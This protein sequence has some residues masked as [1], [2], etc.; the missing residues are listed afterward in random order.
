MRPAAIIPESK[1]LDTLLK[2]FRTNRSHMAIVV[3]EYGSVGGLVTIEDV[4]EQI[5]GEIEDEFDLEGDEDGIQKV[6]E[7]EYVLKGLTEIEEFNEYFSS[8][9]DDDEYETIGGILL[10]AF[11]YVPSKDEGI[12]IE[13]FKFEIVAADTRKIKLVRVA[14]IDVANQQKKVS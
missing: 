9:L 2:E 4:L 10:Q 5:V 1:R 14:K 13:N 6:A 8:Q 3:D 11:G 7:N 12:E